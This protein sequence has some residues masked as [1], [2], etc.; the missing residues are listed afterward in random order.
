MNTLQDFIEQE[1]NNLHFDLAAYNP[2]IKQVVATLKLQKQSITAAESLTAG[3]FQATLANISGASNVFSGGLVT[4]SMEMKSKL[5]KINF[6]LLQKYGVI[7]QWTAEQMALQSA[8]VMQSDWGVGL[9]GVAG[10]ETLEQRQVGT[11]YIGISNKTDLW[12]QEF[13]FKG[14]RQM[15]RE[16]SVVASF[17]MLATQL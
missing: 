1:S 10:P 9:T 6:N 15:I 7:S 4:Y 16:K 17:I 13:L 12:C 3:L 2:V 5:L 8:T 14:Q 11:V